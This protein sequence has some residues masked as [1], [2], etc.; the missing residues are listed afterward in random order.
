LDKEEHNLEDFLLWPHNSQDST[1]AA[2][3]QHD[4]TSITIRVGLKVVRL[5][6]NELLEP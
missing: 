6:I 2:I 1:V 5:N 4:V 3:E